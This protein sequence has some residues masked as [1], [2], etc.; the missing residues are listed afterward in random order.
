MVLRGPLASELNSKTIYLE[1]IV[2]KS[3]H[4]SPENI[5]VFVPGDSRLLT[6]F[7]PG[8]GGLRR[9]KPALSRTPEAQR[10]TDRAGSS[11]VLREAGR[12]FVAD[13]VAGR[14]QFR[15]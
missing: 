12:E 8:A 10:P 3:S 9:G 14:G 6:V 4:P 5:P 1:E 11:G 7:S 15:K 2:G 13:W